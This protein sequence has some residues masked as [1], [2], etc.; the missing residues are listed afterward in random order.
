MTQSVSLQDYVRDTLLA[1]T[2]G[3]REAQRHDEYGQLIGRAAR[4]DG[5]PNLAL[6]K[7]HNVVTTVAFDVAT[8]VE[9]ATAGKIGG[10]VKVV[11]LGD[12]GANGEK[13]FKN[14]AVSRVTF[15][16][17]LAM[18][19]PEEQTSAEAADRRRSSEAMGRIAQQLNG[20]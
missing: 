17:T 20:P 19:R 4:M 8:T 15:A 11:A 6:D 14:S 12:F 1:I 10:S 2:A 18:P 7:Q 13:G 5:N 9:E 3:I 16:V